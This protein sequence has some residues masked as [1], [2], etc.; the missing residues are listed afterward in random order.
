[1]VVGGMVL[2]LS[3]G[4][5]GQS[6]PHFEVAVIRPTPAGTSGG[7]SFSVFEGGRLRITNEPVKLLIRVAF[8][9]ENAQIAGGPTWLDTDRYDIEAKTG[10]PEK[11]KPGQMSSLMQSLPAERFNLRFHRETRELS[12]CKKISVAIKPFL[13]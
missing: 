9:I 6:P 4:G 1:M 10:H 11:M 3:K 13:G 12:F 8:Q 5:P 7:T 2:S